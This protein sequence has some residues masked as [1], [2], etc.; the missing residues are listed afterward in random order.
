MQA[1]EAA[2]LLQPHDTLGIPLGPGQPSDFLHALGDREDWESLDIFGALLIDLFAVF[3]KPGV[4][5]LSGFFGPAERFLVDSGANVEFLPADFRRFGPIATELHPR[6]VAT[7]ATPPDADGWMSLSLHAGATIP[8][9]KAAGADPERLLVVETNP[10]APRTFGIGPDHRRHIAA[11]AKGLAGAAQH[12]HAHAMVGRQ[13]TTCVVERHP[14]AVGDGIALGRTVE[15]DGGH[16]AV[17]GNAEVPGG[18][19]VGR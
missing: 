11:H 18:T 12:H 19:V 7:L 15:P 2:A 6:V 9:L 16:L 8:V 10:A 4:R 5:Y 3:T 14:H 13:R 17:T 1:S